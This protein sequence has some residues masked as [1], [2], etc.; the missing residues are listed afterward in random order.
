[1]KLK[2]KEM[3]NILREEYEKRVDHYIN[4]SEIEIKD[5]KDNDLISSAKGLKIKDKAGF[6]YTVLD[7]IQDAGK[8]FVK[9][10]KP[11]E[12]LPAI[13]MPSASSPMH[14]KE[15]KEES[16]K[17]KDKEKDLKDRLRGDVLPR[18]KDVEYKRSLKT[19]I[20]AKS[21][22]DVFPS[23]GETILVPIEEFEDNFTLWKP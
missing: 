23:E 3:I 14:E 16:P 10:L 11:G 6:I 17:K 20:S 22:A 2:K 4:L 18:N 1:M 9:L 21:A 15:E 19:N 12:A 13:D 5:K 7:V 8:V